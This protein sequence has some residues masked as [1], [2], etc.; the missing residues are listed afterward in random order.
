MPEE[1]QLNLRFVTAP[2]PGEGHRIRVYPPLYLQKLLEVWERPNSAERFLNWWSTIHSANRQNPSE[3]LSPQHFPWLRARQKQAFELPSWRTSFSI[4]APFMRAAV[5][6]TVLF[7]VSVRL[8]GAILRPQPG[9]GCNVRPGRF[10]ALALTSARAGAAGRA[11]WPAM[12]PGGISR[13]TARPAGTALL[14]S[15][16]GTEPR[17]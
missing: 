2:L 3:Q 14:R 6:G 13:A 15:R 17:T 11:F 4:S 5:L 16:L 7:P 8:L 12:T 9:S 1:E 10:P